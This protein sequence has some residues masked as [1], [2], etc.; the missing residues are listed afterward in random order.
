MAKTTITKREYHELCGL[1]V[2]S[3][4]HN[5]ALREICMAAH[6]ITGEPIDDDTWGG[7]HCGDEVYSTIEGSAEELLR[8]LEIT[9][10]D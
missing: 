4:R 1:M 9:V 6:D 3:A 2:L 5:R 7:G 8:R 10:E